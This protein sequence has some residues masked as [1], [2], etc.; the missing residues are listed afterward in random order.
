MTKEIIEELR[1][2]LESSNTNLGRQ[3]TKRK[4]FIDGAI[5]IASR[6]LTIVSQPIEVKD[7]PIVLKDRMVVSKS[8]KK[9]DRLRT[10]KSSF[11][12]T[13]SES[14]A[15]DEQLGTSPFGGAQ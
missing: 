2:Y 9:L 1:Q 4:D 10:G 3:T 7:D 6:E 14:M 13:E 8:S 11:Q 12:M 15:T 5:A